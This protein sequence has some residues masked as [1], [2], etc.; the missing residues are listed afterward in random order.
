MKCLALTAAF[1][2]LISGGAI[3]APATYVLDKTH[4]DVAYSL[5]HLG[6][7]TSHGRFGDVDATLVLDPDAPA[8]SKVSAT[9]Q[10]KSIDSGNDARDEHIRGADWFDV[11]KYPTITF[12][13]TKTTPTGANTAKVTGD[14]TIH[15]VTKSVVLDT[16]LTKF[17][18]HPMRKAQTAGIHAT[19][20]IKRSDYGV[21]SSVP[22][23]G[24]EVTIVI[25]GEFP[26]KP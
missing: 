7:S 15:G 2:T 1:A 19:V 17:A 26:A 8:N 3:A 23:I 13:S 22:M 16:T 25:D 12:V 10:V 24:D 11:A 9:I 14:L 6:F 5:S 21:S 20:T 4:M 18:P